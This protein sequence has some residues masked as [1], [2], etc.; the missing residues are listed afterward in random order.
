[1]ADASVKMVTPRAMHPSPGSASVGAVGSSAGT[2]PGSSAGNTPHS[3]R[4]RGSKR[5]RRASASRS[6]PSTLRIL[7]HR[8]H[9]KH[10]WS[11]VS[12][13]DGQTWQQPLPP[14]PAAILLVAVHVPP[15][16]TQAYRPNATWSL[17]PSVAWGPLNAAA[18]STPRSAPRKPG[19][20]TGNRCSSGPSRMWGRPPLPPPS[21]CGNTTYK[22]RVK[23]PLRIQMQNPRH[24]GRVE[25]GEAEGNSPW[26]LPPLKSHVDRPLGPLLEDLRRLVG[27]Q[28]GLQP[29]DAISHVPLDVDRRRPLVMDPTAVRARGCCRSPLAVLPQPPQVQTP[30]SM[31]PASAFA[32]AHFHGG[33]LRSPELPPPWPHPSLDWPSL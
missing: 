31:P 32:G 8:G 10:L 12:S 24:L 23:F 29:L 16:R 1:M 17:P 9:S 18:S 27:E 30:G 19:L 3:Q 13:T 28:H 5:A 21:G 4:H 6:L 25:A 2:S 26:Q 20:H 7:P 22:A 14:Q 11:G 33:H 15:D